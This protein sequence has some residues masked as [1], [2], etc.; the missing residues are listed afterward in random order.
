LF[1]EEKVRGLAAVLEEKELEEGVAVLRE[2]L[3]GLLQQESCKEHSFLDF[4]SEIYD[5][6]VGEELQAIYEKSHYSPRQFERKTVELTGLSPKKLRKAAR[7][8]QVRLR[9]FFNPEIDLHDCMNDYGYYDYAHFSKDFKESIGLTPHEYKNWM[10]EKL[11]PGKKQ[12]D[13]V[14]LQEE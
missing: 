10:L 13:V 14:F 8:N 7:F 12:K 2:F 3:L 9:I 11:K 4:L 5:Q 6:P 1:G